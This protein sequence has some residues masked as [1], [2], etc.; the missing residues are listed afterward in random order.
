MLHYKDY[1]A[2]WLD[3]SVH[4]FL[5]TFPRNS[6]S[7]NTPLLPALTATRP[8]RRFKSS[9]E[10]RSIAAQVTPL[11]Q[12]LLLPTELLL[13]TQSEIFFGFDEV[14]FFPES[15]ID[16]KPQSGRI[17]GPARINQATLDEFEKWIASNGCS[18]ALGDGDGLNFIVKCTGKRSTCSAIPWNS[19]NQLLLNS[20]CVLRPYLDELDESPN[21]RKSGTSDRFSSPFIPSSLPSRGLSM[22]LSWRCAWQRL[23]RRG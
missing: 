19:P 15:I 11:G 2:G 1:I 13:A 20:R 7:Q 23:C 4:D 16:P 3:S 12:G 10:L 8:P 21:T 9:P 17:V 5:K 14:W 18:L 6:T 22:P